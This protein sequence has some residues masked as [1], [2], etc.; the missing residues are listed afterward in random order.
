VVFRRLGDDELALQLADGADGAAVVAP[1]FGIDGLL[2]EG[3]ELLDELRAGLGTG[4]LTLLALGF[5]VA[6]A[7]ARC[8]GGKRLW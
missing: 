2:D 4:F 1:A 7:A 5:G 6:A 8:G 3:G